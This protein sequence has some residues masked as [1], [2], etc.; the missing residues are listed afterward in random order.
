MERIMLLVALQTEQICLVCSIS[1]CLIAVCHADL[2]VSTFQSEAEP[3]FLIFH[4]VKRDFR[5]ALLLKVGNDGLPHQLGVTH[6]VEHLKGT[7]VKGKKK[8]Q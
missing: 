1:S 8:N 7:T 4:K 5:V 3:R 6:H 2:N